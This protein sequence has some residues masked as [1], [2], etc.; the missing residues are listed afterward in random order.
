MNPI[1]DE[2]KQHPYPATHGSHPPC[3]F[4]PCCERSQTS[5][6]EPRRHFWEWTLTV[7][8]LEKNPMGKEENLG[9]T[10]TSELEPKNKQ[11]TYT[12]FDGWKMF[13]FFKIDHYLWQFLRL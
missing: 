7:R 10:I 4:A 2:K 11:A 13:V 3:F 12:F 9:S 5:V 1:G 6:G 8:M